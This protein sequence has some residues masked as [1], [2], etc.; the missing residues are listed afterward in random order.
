MWNRLFGFFLGSTV[1]GGL[2][3]YYIYD[4]YKLANELLT[5]DINVSGI[6]IY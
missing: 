2:A 5:E 6:H 4:E 3:Y 1:A